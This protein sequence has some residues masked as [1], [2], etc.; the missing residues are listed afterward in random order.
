MSTAAAP[1]YDGV[2]AQREIDGGYSGGLTVTVAQPDADV[3]RMVFVDSD[4]V[5]AW[6]TLTPEQALEL[7]AALQEAASA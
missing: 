6:L 5:A 7:A 3:P 4:L 2:I 1:T